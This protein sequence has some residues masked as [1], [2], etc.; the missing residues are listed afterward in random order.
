MSVTEKKSFITL[1]PAHRGRPFTIPPVRCSDQLR[2]RRGLCKPSPP[3]WPSQPS[4]VP[5]TGPVTKPRCDGS[6]ATRIR[7]E[8]ARA[9]LKEERR[10]C[11]YVC[12]SAAPLP[13]SSSRGAASFCLPAVAYTVFLFSRKRDTLLRRQALNEKKSE[14]RKEF[15][16]FLDNSINFFFD[17]ITSFL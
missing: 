17:E 1:T 11:R 3:R 12:R 7:G 2:A 8:G 15:L 10:S 16:M 9:I 14:E 13:A 4:R 6:T 5:L